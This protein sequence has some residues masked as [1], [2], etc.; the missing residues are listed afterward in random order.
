MRTLAGFTGEN[1][2]DSKA[3]LLPPPPPLSVLA[4]GPFLLGEA[5][6]A[7]GRGVTC[8]RSSAMAHL[9][10][11]WETW[12]LFW[13]GK[14]KRKNKGSCFGE[15]GFLDQASNVPQEKDMHP[16][17]LRQQPILKLDLLKVQHPVLRP[18]CTA[19]N[20]PPPLGSASTGKGGACF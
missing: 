12:V 9:T 18:K 4:R 14:S 8:S 6:I 19:S 1:S 5:L 20:W 3:Q 10:G 11:N 2:R 15:P 13:H 7:Q 16:R 17:I